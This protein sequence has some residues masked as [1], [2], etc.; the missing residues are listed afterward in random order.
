MN[1]AE[2]FWNAFADS[3]VE[4]E[5]LQ[6]KIPKQDARF[7][8]MLVGELLPVMCADGLLSEGELS[9]L[10]RFQTSAGLDIEP[11]CAAVSLY[12]G[13]EGDSNQSS[14]WER[15][16]EVPLGASME[17][18]NNAYR[19]KVKEYHPDRL[20]GVPQGV[21]R[22]AEEKLKEINEAYAMLSSTTGENGM[23][24]N[25]RVFTGEDWKSLSDTS[26]GDIVLCPNCTQKN[27]LPEKSR[28][29][30]ARCGACHGYL[31]WTAFQHDF[32]FA[33]TGQETKYDDNPTIKQQLRNHGKCERDTDHHIGYQYFLQR[34]W[35]I[36]KQH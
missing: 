35:L 32:M 4:P 9:W 31:A 2:K 14:K 15:A 28:F 16:L 18:I 33:L 5:G 20:N 13:R 19:E 23:L 1:I 27:R 30:L 22:L 29:F 7:L 11:M 8:L 25:V 10:V 26:P 34:H 3:P 12:C 17:C 21:R 24:R 36:E 6:Y